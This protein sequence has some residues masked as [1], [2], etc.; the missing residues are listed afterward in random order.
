MTEK[1][2]K[3]CFNTQKNDFDQQTVNT[4]QVNHFFDQYFE[5]E[6]QLI[7]AIFHKNCEVL[8]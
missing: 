6:K 2:G 3:T 5:G 4:Q 7:F 1:D 8:S